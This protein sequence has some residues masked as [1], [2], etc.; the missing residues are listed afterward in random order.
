MTFGL[1]DCNSFYC[2]CER[3]FRP[4]TRGK[5]IVV[6]SNNDGCAIA[7]S[8]EAKAIGFGEMCEPY[9]KTKDRIAKHK[10]FVFSSNYTLYDDISKRVMKILENYTPRLEVYSVD[11]AFLDLNG[12]DNF[13]LFEFGIKIRKELL[14]ST[15]I[16]VGVGIS[17]TKVLS[18]AANKIAKKN[19]GVWVM[20]TD[21][22]IDAVLKNFPTKDIW[23]IGSASARKLSLLG[24]N[25]AYEFKMY[26]N[27]NLIQKLLTKTGR[28]V[29]EELRGVSCLGMENVDDKK[30][31]ANT[32]SFG[33][34]TYAKNELKE[35]IA[36]FATKVAEKLRNQKSVT[37]SLT[38][39]IHTNAFKEYEQYYGSGHHT[40]QTGTSDTIKI[41][42]AAHEVLESIYR[43]GFGYKKAGVILNHIVPVGENQLDLFNPDP[44]D[45]KNL[46]IVLDAI[47]N[48]FGPRTI[49]SAA[50]GINQAWK[51]RSDYISKRFTTNWDEILAI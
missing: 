35:A 45:N 51:L 10:V 28:E 15:G 46:S 44:T 38:V 37:Y 11:E 23:G 9:F 49:K 4:D 3:V 41:I 16:P 2:S 30:I 19:K 20:N 47:N 5:P 48:R 14:N 34:D 43:P 29:Q 24:I 13:D 7:F 33:R 27:D 25:T 22:E 1:V 39:F 32:R 17:K 31:I 26:K 12:Y 21:K 42:K 36:T 50:C 8:K 6:L 40:F 18:K